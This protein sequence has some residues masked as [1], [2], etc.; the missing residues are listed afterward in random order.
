M[1][2]LEQLKSLTRWWSFEDPPP[3]FNHCWKPKPIPSLPGTHYLTDEQVALFCREGY[4]VVPDLFDAETVHRTIETTWLLLPAW[5]KRDD[6]RT[7]T[8][9]TEDDCHAQSLEG[10]RGRLKYRQSIRDQRWI[11]DMLFANEM[12]I[13]VAESLLGVGTVAQPA[14][15]RG[16]YPIVPT[17]TMVGKK[18]N[19]HI[20]RHPFQI[21]MVG[22]LNDVKPGCGAFTVWPG[23]HRRLWPHF[24]NRGTD[25][26]RRSWET[27][28]ASIKKSINSIELTAP[29]GSVIF[30]H[31]R[32]VHAAGI[33][34]GPDIRFAI[35]GDLARV[36][37][38]PY[39]AI[40]FY[41][42]MWYGWGERVTQSNPLRRAI[43]RKSARMPRV[44]PHSRGTPVAI[45]F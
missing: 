40:N 17:P 30:W 36:D 42:D 34:G 9:M 39:V 15:F 22:Y 44:V 18:P 3:K 33:N 28:F 16:L 29:A 8:G 13:A 12:V 38:D 19:G 2:M 14:W 26:R 7:W 6:P 37:Y 10:R 4:L 23:S 43:A 20:D 41:D 35:L 32:L 45:P 21:G 25:W 27:T 5:F 11:G 1:F 31:S 24:R